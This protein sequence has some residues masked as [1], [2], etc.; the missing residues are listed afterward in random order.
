MKYMYLDGY[1]ILED[2]TKEVLNKINLVGIV[3]SVYR[4]KI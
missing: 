2:N 3:E 1:Y 4:N